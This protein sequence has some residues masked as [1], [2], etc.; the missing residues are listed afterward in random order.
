MDKILGLILARSGSKRLPNKNILK[1]KDKP[2]IYYTIKAAKKAKSISEIYLSSDSQKILE[3]ASRYD[4]KTFKRDKKYAEDETTS[5]ESLIEFLVSNP[6]ISKRYKYLC[7]LQ[8]TSP[9]RDEDDID[10]A[11]EF[12]NKSSARSLISVCNPSYKFAKYI[13]LNPDNTIKGYAS[14]LSNEYGFKSNYYPNGAIY[15]FEIDLF[16]K[17]K[18]LIQKPCLPYLMSN[19]K[20][21][22]IDT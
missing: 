8:P 20:S 22:D 4:C 7:L 1:L 11:I 5:E 16:L 2:L 3:I 15:I 6:L 12:L 13:C 19:S 9:L 18:K 14:N 10:E 21:V 17:T